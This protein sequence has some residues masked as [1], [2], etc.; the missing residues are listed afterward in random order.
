MIGRERIGVLGIRGGGDYRME[1]G[2]DYRMGGVET[3]VWKGW[4]KY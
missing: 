3:I 2:E 1:G 4:R